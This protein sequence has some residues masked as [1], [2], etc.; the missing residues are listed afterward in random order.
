MYKKD[1]RISD[2]QFYLR[3]L[4]DYTEKSFARK[5]LG[6]IQADTPNTSRKIKSILLNIAKIRNKFTS[7]VDERLFIP[8]GISLVVRAFNKW[9]DKNYWR[10]FRAIHL[11]LNLR[12]PDLKIKMEYTWLSFTR[13]LGVHRDNATNLPERFI[14]DAV[15]Y[16]GLAERYTIKKM[17]LTTR[18]I[19]IVY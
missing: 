4:I 18:H 3:Y 5:L 10:N 7:V 17:I 1:R 16:D 11:M 13:D 12:K 15:V 14:F 6:E 2:K 8:I 19:K 9:L